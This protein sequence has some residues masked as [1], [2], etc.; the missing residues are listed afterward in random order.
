MLY[1]EENLAMMKKAGAWNVIKTELP[2]RQE[3]ETSEH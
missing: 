2:F 1:V 3:S